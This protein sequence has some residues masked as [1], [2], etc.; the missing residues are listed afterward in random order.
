MV[1]KLG[2]LEK[3]VLAVSIRTLGSVFTY[4]M[5]WNIPWNIPEKK[6]NKKRNNG[7]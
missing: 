2:S 4:G 3:H 1:Q 5:E 7:R 6:W